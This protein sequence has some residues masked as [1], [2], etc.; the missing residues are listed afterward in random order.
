MHTVSVHVPQ[1]VPILHTLATANPSL[2]LTSSH[3]RPFD[4]A[5]ARVHQPSISRWT[6]FN[7]RVLSEAYGHILDEMVAPDSGA[8]AGP[9]FMENLDGLKQM[10]LDHMFPR[11]KGPIG[12][13]VDAI[14]GYLPGHVPAVAIGLNT[15]LPQRRS[16]A[17]TFKAGPTGRPLIFS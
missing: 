6:Q 3:S 10:F 17:V 14:N 11:L 8:E 7:Y 4:S 5:S 15:P 13:G 2:H 12:K 1:G 9:F 16:S